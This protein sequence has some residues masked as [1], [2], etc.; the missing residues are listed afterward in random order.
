MK[1]DLWALW[2]IVVIYAVGCY[3]VWLAAAEL[4]K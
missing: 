3:V 4:W 1:A 2:A